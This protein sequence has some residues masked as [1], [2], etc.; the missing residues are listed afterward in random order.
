[1]PGCILQISSRKVEQQHLFFIPDGGSIR[2]RWRAGA[3][4]PMSF[5]PPLVPQQHVVFGAA[6]CGPWYHRVMDIFPC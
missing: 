4:N 1:M 6:S 3:S 2:D 5:G